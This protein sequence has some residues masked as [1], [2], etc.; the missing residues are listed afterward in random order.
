[1]DQ[2][3]K[4][5]IKE[6]IESFDIDGDLLDYAYEAYDLFKLIAVGEKIDV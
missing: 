2:V 6:M 1:M 5:Q 4:D 3:I